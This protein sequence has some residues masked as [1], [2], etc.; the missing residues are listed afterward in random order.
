MANG[1]LPQTSKIAYIVVWGQVITFFIC[2]S[3]LCLTLFYKTYSDPVV[4][5]ALI[6]LTGTLGGNL[7][8]ILGGPRQMMPVVTTPD[9]TVT[10]TPPKVEVSQ[11]EQPKEP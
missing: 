7:G 8:S 6:A 5:T 1:I 10:S 2:V 3:A 4:L 9:I 11:P